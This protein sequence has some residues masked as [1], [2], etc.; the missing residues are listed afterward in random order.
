MKKETT[1]I[2]PVGKDEV[3]ANWFK[4]DKCGNEM[5]LDDFNYCPN[6]GREISK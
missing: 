6:C 2:T 5:I 1:T 3:Y 4:C